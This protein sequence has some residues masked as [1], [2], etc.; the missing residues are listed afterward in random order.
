M[1]DDG[2]QQPNFNSQ[3]SDK[4]EK[5]QNQMEGLRGENPLYLYQVVYS[6]LRYVEE[7][8]KKDDFEKLSKRVDH[9]ENNDLKHLTSIEDYYRLSN[10]VRKLQEK[11]DILLDD[12]G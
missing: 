4:I 12:K 3:F 6:N 10:T 5:L 11:L 1:P 9:I 7:A 2:I 8:Q